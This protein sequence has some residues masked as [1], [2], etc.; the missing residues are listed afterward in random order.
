M[1]THL[2]Q[3][4]PESDNTLIFIFQFPDRASPSLHSRSLANFLV[5]GC[6][7][8]G[9]SIVKNCF[10]KPLIADS[11]FHLSVSHSK[12]TLAIA[13]A[14]CNIGLDIEFLRY[15]EKWQAVY[16]WI[17]Q[18]ENPEETPTVEQY[19][20]CWTAKE[21]LLKATGFG[22]D[23]G[24]H[25][26]R[27]PGLIEN[28]VHYRTRMEGQ[29]YWTQCLSVAKEGILSITSA[30]LRKSQLF[31]FADANGVIGQSLSFEQY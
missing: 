31:T 15:P 22:L 19:L 28:G 23:Y 3:L 30:K 11:P 7:G 10:G 6:C 24:L 12:S 20:Q 29:R 5:A 25:K 9:F 1:L 27:V 18:Q 4:A 17:N 21:S 13:L 26:V 16:Q 2:P 14:T 8:D